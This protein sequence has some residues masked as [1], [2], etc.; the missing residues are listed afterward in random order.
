MAEL[1]AIAA[2]VQL[3]DVALRASGEIRD[4]LDAYKHTGK[5]VKALRDCKIISIHNPL[6]PTKH[7][8]VARH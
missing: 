1:G 7:R 5:E 4:F 2:V 3:V 6:A 8:S